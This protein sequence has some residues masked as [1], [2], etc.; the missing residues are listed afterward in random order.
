MGVTSYFQIR[1]AIARAEALT[2]IAKLDGVQKRLIYLIA[3]EMAQG[4]GVRMSQLK[5]HREFGTMPTI[6]SR[7]NEMIE[8]GLLAR[9]ELRIFLEE[10]LSRIPDFDIAPGR[11]PKVLYGIVG[12]VVDLPLVWQA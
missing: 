6:L 9:A 3:D 2:P 1:A 8:S 7:L 5:A 10:W 4:Q 12:T 11:T